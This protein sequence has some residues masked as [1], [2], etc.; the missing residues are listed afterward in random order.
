MLWVNICYLTPAYCN[1]W[2][3]SALPTGSK[4]SR[5]RALA[6]LKDMLRKHPNAA[7]DRLSRSSALTSDLQFAHS[8]IAKAMTKHSWTRNTAWASKFKKYVQKA[9]PD[10]CKSVG[11]MAKAVK[12]NSLALAFLTSVVRDKPRT[13]TCVDAAKRAI[14]LLRA[15][16]GWVSLDADPNV[17]LL[18]RSVRHSFARTVRQSPAFPA[19]FARAVL[20]QWG[21]SNVWWKRMVALM[22]TLDL[23]TMARGAEVVSCRREGI[24]WVR[25]DGT[26]V[27][28]PLYNPASSIGATTAALLNHRRGFL[29]LFPSR[30]NHQFTSTCVPVISS[31]VVSLL[32]RHVKW[33]DTVRGPIPGCLFPARRSAR[34]DGPARELTFPLFSLSLPCRLTLSGLLSD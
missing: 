3:T 32:A 4:V 2:L 15:L 14:N 11:G 27:R 28:V 25:P 31:A 30:K 6:I 20:M 22:I 23:C 1:I 26:Q 12:S 16:M 17:R 18:A 13:K 9:C 8:V 33:L 10:L 29:V 5:E 21:I 19:I 7:A 34:R 24:E